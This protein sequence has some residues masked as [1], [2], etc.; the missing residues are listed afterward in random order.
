MPTFGKLYGQ[1]TVPAGGWAFSATSAGGSGAESITGGDYYM[2]ALLVEFADKLD[3]AT[4][5]PWTVSISGGEGGTGQIIVSTNG[6]GNGSITWTATDFRDLLGFTGNLSGAGLHTSTNSARGVWLP[7]GPHRTLFGDDDAGWQESDARATESPTGHVKV[8]QGNYKQVQAVEWM[9][10]SHAYCRIAGEGAVANTS[11]EIF[12]RDC[13]QGDAMGLSAGPYGKPG[14]P[15]KYY[16]D[17]DTTTNVE[18][19]V[20][21]EQLRQFTAEQMSEGWIELWRIPL[22]RLVKVPA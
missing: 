13:I 11:F 8:F 7:D 15:I 14:G 10:I 20:A 16:P 2:D 3:D 4:S 19:V 17:A 22:D 6:N 18:Y 9:G 5:D 1:I 12:W 21:G